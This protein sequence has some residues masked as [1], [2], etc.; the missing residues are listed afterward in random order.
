MTRAR[1]DGHV[2]PPDGALVIGVWVDRETADPRFRVTLSNAASG[3]PP[4]VVYETSIDRV[5]DLVER[6]L[7]AFVD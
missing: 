5:T 3:T 4:T 7:R 1:F 6:W 2:D